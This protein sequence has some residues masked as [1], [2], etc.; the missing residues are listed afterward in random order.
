MPRPSLWTPR[1]TA[2]LRLGFVMSILGV[3]GGCGRSQA[4][5]KARKTAAFAYFGTLIERNRNLSTGNLITGRSTSGPEH[6]GFIKEPWPTREQ[7]E[8]G[9]GKADHARQD[10]DGVVLL[11]WEPDPSSAV[12][13][14]EGDKKG[15][16]AYLRA[17]FDPQG[18]LDSFD[19]MYGIAAEHVGRKVS[20]W[21]WRGP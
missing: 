12:W 10:T 7:V 5:E 14:P 17:H 8:S 19:A 11:W 1:R 3:L 13:T 2:L 21:E 9:A 20:E 16:H 15:F 18:R 6:P 4:E